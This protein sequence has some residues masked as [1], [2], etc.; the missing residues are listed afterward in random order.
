[1][2]EEKCNSIQATFLENMEF[3]AIWEEI[4]MEVTATLD[5]SHSTCI[6]ETVD[7]S[8]R[9]LLEIDVYNLLGSAITTGYVFLSTSA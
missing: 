9:K 2:N 8:Y 5:S 3:D 7:N 4:R 1:M 6:L